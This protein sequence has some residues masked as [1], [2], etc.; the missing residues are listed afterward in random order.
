VG[1]Y[2][3][4]VDSVRMILKKTKSQIGEVKWDYKELSTRV[5]LLLSEDRT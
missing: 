3:D 2:I 4:C 5:I 1:V